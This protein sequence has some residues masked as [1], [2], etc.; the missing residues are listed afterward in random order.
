MRRELGHIIHVEQ[1]MACHQVGK[2]LTASSLAP[3]PQACRQTLPQ[4]LAI[5]ARPRMFQSA[6]GTHQPEKQPY[7]LQSH[8][9]T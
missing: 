6:G 9:E 1:E 4:L 5:G 7:F 8:T 2:P 3:P